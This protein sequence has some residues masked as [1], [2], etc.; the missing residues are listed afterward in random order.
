MKAKTT[1]S[2]AVVLAVGVMLA[3]L[4]ACSDDSGAGNDP[5]AASSTTT[6]LTTTD[7]TV[8]TSS[9]ASPVDSTATAQP[10]RPA[11]D[12]LVGTLRP[13]FGSVLGQGDIVDVRDEVE[14]VD[15]DATHVQAATTHEG[16]LWAAVDR[17]GIELLRVAPSGAESA[18]I[19][20]MAGESSFFESGPLLAG[21]GSLW[22]PT[23][24]G[25]V[26]RVDPEAGSVTATVE[27]EGTRLARAQSG[28]RGPHGLEIEAIADGGG[29]WMQSDRFRGHLGRLD[30]GSDEVA[31][32]VDLFPGQS[33][34]GL[35]PMASAYGSLWI[36]RESAVERLDPTTLAVTT[37]Y[38]LAIGDVRDLVVT[39]DA[40]W[41][42]GAEATVRIDPVDER[43][44]AT[45]PLAA[46]NTRFGVVVDAD[47]LVLSGNQA[48]RIDTD[49]NMANAQFLLGVDLQSLTTTATHLWGV[50][51]EGPSPDS[52]RQLYR[53]PLDAI[54]HGS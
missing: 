20:L 46:L 52:G 6:A 44:V 2:P 23:R 43:V 51:G 36:G 28:I 31:T 48:F 10:F 53:I 18:A 4:A 50:G 15:V 14:N 3:A 30:A 12:E 11:G 22:L 19:S 5:G 42:V 37:I 54:G 1:P 33:G 45:I 41:V 47:L 13:Q 24:D 8:S 49:T 34:G 16:D 32:V 39:D 17:D 35:L 25:P 38:D 21:A 7:A 27:L 40:L 26:L 9:R 29:V